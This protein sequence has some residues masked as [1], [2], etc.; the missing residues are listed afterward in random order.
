MVDKNKDKFD[1]DTMD[2]KNHLDAS[3]DIDKIKVSEDLIAKT[4]LAIKDSEKENNKFVNTVSDNSED[5][6]D[7]NDESNNDIDTMGKKSAIRFLP[8]KLA[9][10][11]A[12]VL[13]FIM[14]GTQSFEFGGSKKDSGYGISTK[15]ESA[16][17]STTNIYESADYDKVADENFRNEDSSNGA[18]EN[19]IDKSISNVAE[20]DVVDDAALDANLNSATSE[21]DEFNGEVLEGNA[22][23][24]SSLYPIDKK[25][26]SEFTIKDEYNNLISTSKDIEFVK[27]LY[28]VLDE[29]P[30]TMIQNKTLEYV[31]QFDILTDEKLRYTILIG[32][33]I[34]VKTSDELEY[35]YYEI[36][37]INE[38]LVKIENFISTMP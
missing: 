18:K 2:I 30:L 13:I 1:I 23:I 33:G 20:S 5:I 32:S 7:N 29:Y 25:V 12:A 26:I 8:L 27:E 36:N 10:I 37:N 34:Y 16:E 9:T 3:F 11:A 22:Y 35:T 4:L 17:N 21:M 15:N 14:V 19:G 24:I 28:R 31:Y 38:L 6:L